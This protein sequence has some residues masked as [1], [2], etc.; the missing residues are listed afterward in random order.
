MIDT[1]RIRSGFDVELN[2]GAGWF[3]TA[4]QALA[5]AG[6]LV[7]DDA[8]PPF[9]PEAVIEITSVEILFD[10]ERDL[11]I[12]A[13]VDDVARTLLASLSLNEGE[14]G[15]ELVIDTD[16]AGVGATVPFDALDDVVG[17]PTLVKV[18]ADG[19]FEP[20]FAVL[21]N[22]DIQASPQSQEPLPQG[23][24]LPR[25]EAELAQSFLPA[26]KDLVVGIGRDSFPR[27]ANDVWHTEL[28]AEDGSHPLPDDEDPKGTWTVVRLD[29]QQGR[30]RLTLLGKVPI[31]VFPDAK[32]TVTVDL[33]PRLEDG[34]LAFDLSID[35]DVDTGLL[36]DLFAAL[37]GGLIGLI[38]GFFTG[39]VVLEPASG[40]VLAVVALEVAEVIVN[41]EVR[42]QVRARLQEEE[43]R[44]LLVCDDDVIVEAV[45]HADE[46]GGIALGPLSAIPRSIVV[47]RFTPD[48]LHTRF[49]LVTTEYQE[50]A[51]DA[52]GFALAGT[53]GATERF[54]P[55]RASL[56][57]R[58]LVPIGGGGLQVELVYATTD[59]QAE[60]ETQV[61]VRLSLA[62]VV[63]RAA[64]GALRPPLKLRFM[65]ANADI[66]LLDSRVPS[67]CLRAT[68][69]RRRE[70]VVT[71]IRFTTGLELPV[72]EAVR[73]QDAGAIVVQLLQL[74][75]PSD[76]DPYFRSFADGSTDNNFENLPSF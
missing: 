37:T 3:R 31:D 36:G 15:A 67:V 55:R 42:K 40:A 13:R 57:R 2:L 38:V 73:L 54:V 65:P 66:T 45:P 35:T 53:A 46:E 23:E 17:V 4:L 52:A 71:D 43:H 75:H 63:D 9:G 60:E 50:I 20:A 70:T 59:P 8:P 61:E 34:A 25:G 29:P 5:D 6:R 32:V 10:G 14:D 68:N 16:V 62:E 48:P 12:A 64:Q 74:I 26:G 27:F 69:V 47:D 72:S 56:L 21:A 7:Q 30:L 51:C 19:G 28:R 39:G 22:L 58:E 41:D 11:S 18:A 49:V 44:A 76:A 1:A 24:H 33:E